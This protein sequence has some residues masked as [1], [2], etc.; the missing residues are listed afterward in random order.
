ME[1]SGGGGGCRSR[2]RQNLRVWLSFPIVWEIIK[3]EIALR[4]TGRGRGG[5]AGGLNKGEGTKWKASAR[6]GQLTLAN[7]SQPPAHDNK[8][9]LAYRPVHPCLEALP[10]LPFASS[11]PPHLHFAALYPSGVPCTPTRSSIHSPACARPLSHSWKAPVALI[12]RS[13]GFSPTC[14]TPTIL[15]KVYSIS[16]N[17]ENKQSGSKERQFLVR[18][19]GYGRKSGGCGRGG[20]RGEGWAFVAHGRAL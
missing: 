20:R 10:P 4:G 8:I 16:V 3:L 18:G 13:E 1:G 14:P 7:I 11:H 5:I 12:L 2:R 19:G 17:R 9:I 15:Q 6:L